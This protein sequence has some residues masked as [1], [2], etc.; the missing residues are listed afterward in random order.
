VVEVTAPMVASVLS[1]RVVAGQHVRAGDTLLVVE[2]MKMEIPVTAPV[3]GAVAEL[4]VAAAD[5]V[6]QGDVLIRLEPS[7]G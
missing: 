6:E 3:S 5:V 4:R 7:A 1:V 2:T